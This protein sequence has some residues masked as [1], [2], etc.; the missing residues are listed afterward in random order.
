MPYIS[1]ARRRIKLRDL[2]ILVVV[3]RRGSMAKAAAELAISQPAVSRAIRSTAARS[4]GAARQFS[5]S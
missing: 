3:V 4:S 2:H 5:T 1:R